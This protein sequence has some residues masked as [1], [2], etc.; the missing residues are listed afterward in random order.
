[1]RSQVLPESFKKFKISFPET[2]KAHVPFC[3]PKDCLTPTISE[4]YCTQLVQIDCVHTLVVHTLCL[5]KLYW[6]TFIL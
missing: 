5:D 2:G 1:M 3:T 4:H 6:C